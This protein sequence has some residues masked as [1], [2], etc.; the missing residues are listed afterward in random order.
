MDK[1]FFYI[2]IIINESQIILVEYKYKCTP[3]S[4]IYVLSNFKK[5]KIEKNGV[6][7]VHDIE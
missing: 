7:D 4:H 3:L 5:K 1:I 2:S 6:H